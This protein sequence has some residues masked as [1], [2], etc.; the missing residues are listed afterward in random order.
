MSRVI[1][2]MR[3]AGRSGNTTTTS[4][5]LEVVRTDPEKNLIAVKGSVP[6]AKGGLV[7][8]RDA[9]KE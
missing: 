1:K 7:V 9:R 3:M 2:G 6:G 5:N 8:I 4:Q